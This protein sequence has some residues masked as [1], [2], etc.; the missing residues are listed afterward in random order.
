MVW[1]NRTIAWVMPPE[2]ISSP[3]RMKNGTAIS[4]KLSMPLYSRDSSALKNTCWSSAT[5]LR[6]GP[7]SRANTTGMPAASRKMKIQK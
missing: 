4:G 5:R 6:P 7:T 3:A 1:V 2:F